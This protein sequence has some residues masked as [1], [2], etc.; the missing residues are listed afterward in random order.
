MPYNTCNAETFF[1]ETLGIERN[2]LT[3]LLLPSDEAKRIGAAAYNTP[4]IKMYQGPRLFCVLS[5]GALYFKMDVYHYLACPA[6]WF[7]SSDL[8]LRAATIRDYLLIKCSNTEN[9]LDPVCVC[10][11][12]YHYQQNEGGKM[13]RHVSTSLTMVM[14]I[15]KGCV[16][17]RVS[18][19]R[20]MGVCQL[21]DEIEFDEVI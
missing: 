16:C 2:T 11:K 19:T 7:R 18:L 12:C 3:Q 17:V 14:S 4:H 21:T 1:Q 15:S 10:N 20:V 9:W 13:I 6:I 5:F 8:F